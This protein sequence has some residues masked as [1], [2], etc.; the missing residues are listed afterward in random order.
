MNYSALL[1]AAGK[2][3]RL[4]L[5]YNKVFY[6]LN[7]NETVLDRS[8]AIFKADKNCR[9]I[10][11]V[12]AA[13]ELAACHKKYDKD[14]I[15]LVAG[16][17]T[18]AQSSLNGL[19]AVSL[20]KVLIHDAARPYLSADCLQRI[21]KAAETYPVVIPAVKIKDTIK[22]A[23]DDWVKQ[24]LEREELIAVQTPQAFDTWL[25]KDCHEK[26]QA[27]NYSS[28]DDSQVI[29][30][31]SEVAIRVVEG[32]YRNNKITTI[33]DLPPEQLD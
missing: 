9:E 3:L 22:T 24:T 8:I 14:N 23:Q 19:K 29:E 27:A 13:E 10:V 16:G 4:G 30:A 7:E 11:V 21:V 31:F 1:V 5:G 26:A 18:R 33:E 2:G 28:T 6:Q 32:D 12:V 25:I 15:I 20:A 17:A